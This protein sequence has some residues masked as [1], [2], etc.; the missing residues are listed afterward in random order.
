[1]INDLKKIWFI[2]SSKNR[3]KSAIFLFLSLISV[4][5]ETASLGMIVPIISTMIGSQNETFLFLSEFAKLISERWQINSISFLMIFFISIFVAKNIFLFFFAWWTANFVNKVEINLTKKLF[6]SYINQ[7]YLFFI[8]IS[9]TEIVRNIVVEVGNFRKT[10]DNILSIIVELTLLLGILFLLLSVD[11]I[12]TI[13]ILLPVIIFVFLY[14][15]LSK[16][17]TLKLGQKRLGYSNKHMKYVTES[18]NAIKELILYEV[19]NYFQKKQLKEKIN[20]GNVYRHYIVLNSLPR[21]FLELLIISII[22]IIIIINSNEDLN[23][24]IPTLS[25]FALCAIRLLPSATKIVTVTQGIKYKS[26]VIHKMYDLIQKDENYNKELLEIDKNLFPNKSDKNK[27]VINNINFSYFNSNKKV[28]D[29]LSICFEKGKF[30]GLIGASGSGKT[31]LVNLLLGFLKP[32][33]GTIKLDGIDIS[34]YKIDWKSKVGYV[35]QSIFLLDESIINNVAFGVEE[36]K[37]DIKK[38]KE[39]IETVQLTDFINNLENSYKSV[40]GERGSKISGGQVQRLGIARALYNNPDILILD[41][42]TNNLDIDVENKILKDLSKLKGTKTI[43]FIT[44]RENPLIYCD[45]IYE[46]NNG[47]VKKK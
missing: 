37:I 33:D 6:S 4:I 16:K 19:K 40:V 42:S 22:S 39:S 11:L 8:N 18:I 3:I 34:K 45:E 20:V 1:M 47:N 27:F 17:I 41:E 25:L 24:L 14:Y 44:H 46:I 43:I 26:P 7:P 30:Y 10:I 38:V 32:S 12:N 29:N 2:L 23:N 5:F 21:I 35:P 28:V 9:S 15:L 31:T 13:T 36:E